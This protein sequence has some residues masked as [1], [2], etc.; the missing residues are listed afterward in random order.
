MP[1]LD[2]RVEIARTPRSHE[3]A[4]RVLVRRVLH[5]APRAHAAEQM[6]GG[7]THASVFHLSRRLRARL[8]VARARRLFLQTRR[9]FPLSLN[10]RFR[11][12]G[13][14][15][16]PSPRRRGFL[17][18]FPPQ[19]RSRPTDPRGRAGV[20]CPRISPVSRNPGC[21]PS[22]RVPGL[23]QG[24]SRTV[25]F[26]ASPRR[27]VVR[28]RPRSRRRVRSR[29]FARTR[30]LHPR[31]RLARALAVVLL[32]E[33][34]EAHQFSWSSRSLRLMTCEPRNPPPSP[35]ARLASSCACATK[36]SV[37][38]HQRVA[39]WTCSSTSVRRAGRA[40]GRIAGIASPS[41]GMFV[42][43]AGHP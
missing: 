15:P 43:P 11:C 16:R 29:L 17:R 26:E 8:F 27:L 39:G 42:A 14:T 23:G 32:Q 2:D 3:G 1:L 40:R 30:P 9:A 5:R 25:R 35:R 34:P 10:A 6:L 31:R 21:P 38:L 36:V 33:L 7:E 19:P 13:S 37:A 22:R 41:E 12:S 18:R 28:A 4:R 24:T 20:G